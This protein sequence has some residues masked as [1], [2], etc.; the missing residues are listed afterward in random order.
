MKETC[1][2][3]LGREDLLEKEVASHYK[4]LAWEITWSEQPGGLQSMQLQRIRYALV[5][6]Q[7]Q[8]RVKRMG[9]YPKG[10]WTVVEILYRQITI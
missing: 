1:I 3:S 7:Q 9:G 6:D 2:Q 4:I 8:A 10:Q 5:T